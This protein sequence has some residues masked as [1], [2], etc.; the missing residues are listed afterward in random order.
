MWNSPQHCE[1]QYR[2]HSF[3]VC[4]LHVNSKSVNA[5]EPSM[6]KHAYVYMHS[7]G[8]IV[9]SMHVTFPKLFLF[10]VHAKPGGSPAS[11]L[12]IVLLACHQGSRTISAA[13]YHCFSFQSQCWSVKV[14]DGR[15]SRRPAAHKKLLAVSVTSSQWCILTVVHSSVFYTRV[16]L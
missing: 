8:W 16:C 13:A 11:R 7:S 3:E 10:N 9:R 5:I 15:F 12:L 6:V 2:C 1:S 4:M 14:S